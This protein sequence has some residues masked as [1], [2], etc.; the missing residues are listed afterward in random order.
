MYHILA[1]VT[2]SAAVLGSA[3]AVLWMQDSLD[4]SPEVYIKKHM[5][6]VRSDWV[7]A[8]LCSDERAWP[9]TPPAKIPK[10]MMMA[11]AIRRMIKLV[12]LRVKTSEVEEALARNSMAVETRGES[13]ASDI[14]FICCEKKKYLC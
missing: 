4:S 7:M 2:Y 13:E 12:M 5:P 14:V 8:G 9:P 6:P 11:L 3:Q 1:A 10:P